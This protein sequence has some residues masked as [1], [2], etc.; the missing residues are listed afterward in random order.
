[1]DN[2][3]ERTSK[4]DTQT[5]ANIDQ[6]VAD[7]TEKGEEVL[8]PSEEL[9]NITEHMK[10]VQLSSSDSDDKTDIKLSSDVSQNISP[11]MDEYVETV[12]AGVP[13]VSEVIVVNDK[14][15][16]GQQQEFVPSCEM[17]DA[18]LVSSDVSMNDVV[19]PAKVKED[20]L[21]DFQ[22][23][24]DNLEKLVD[25]A[26]EVGN[27]HH[28]DSNRKFMNLESIPED[29]DRSSC[30]DVEPK[31]CASE[32]LYQELVLNCDIE[33]TV[34]DDVETT[35]STAV[36]TQSELKDGPR[37]II[38][39]N[40]RSDFKG[41]PLPSANDVKS[42]IADDM[43]FNVGDVQSDLENDSLSN[44]LD[45]FPAIVDNILS[46]VED[47]APSC[48][49]NTPLH[50][51]DETQSSAADNSQPD[52]HKDTRSDTEGDPQSDLDEIQ[53]STADGEDSC[54]GHVLVITADA[55]WESGDNQQNCQ[56]LESTLTEE[57][58]P[59]VL[60]RSENLESQE[61]EQ[62][63][64][65]TEEDD[66][67]T[68]TDMETSAKL[69]KQSTTESEI[70]GESESED[71]RRSEQDVLKMLE[72]SFFESEPKEN[73]DLEA[74][75]RLPMDSEIASEQNLDT[76]DIAS[77]QLRE[78]EEISHFDIILEE[79]VTAEINEPKT[80]VEGVLL[81]HVQKES[82]ERDEGFL[83]ENAKREISEVVNELLDLNECDK[84]T[85]VSSGRE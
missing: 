13:A 16:S 67:E 68:D 29:D 74:E 53:T 35:L 15:T 78:V 7:K 66:L 2:V 19:V 36:E 9:L 57:K 8:P 81:N 69:E 58:F 63:E 54:Q 59:Q 65:E 48:V 71:D 26:D 39:D 60:A 23:V 38:E 31:V 6:N 51:K 3:A 80:V 22:D 11:Y 75:G 10:D 5:A 72:Q 30:C 44:A 43:Q 49:S 24:N 83:Q 84:I 50:A 1:M 64:T 45:D 40:V 34:E 41:D 82:V 47:A 33:V 37:L 56:E 85:I 46:N 79:R 42:A 25:E 70:D 20:Y 17:R 55:N 76:S 73:L 21:I 52:T 27:P 32:N 14:D 62:P 28:S 77:E 4:Q 18:V 61:E 12:N